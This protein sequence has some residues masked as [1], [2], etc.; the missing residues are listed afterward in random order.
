MTTPRDIL[1]E[2]LKQAQQKMTITLSETQQGWCHMMVANAETQK[3]VL[4]VV[5]TS[6]TKKIENPNQDVRQHK[7]ELPNGYSGRSFDFNYV[8]P[9]LQ[10]FFPR[11][12]MAESGWLTRSLEQVHAFTLD[13]PGKIRDTA[14]KMAFLNILK[15]IEVNQADVLEYLVIIFARLLE[16]QTLQTFAVASFR[17]NTEFTIIGVVRLLEQHFFHVYK[18]SGAARLPVIAIYT[19][20]NLMM[21]H[22]RYI[23]KQLLPL[24]S[25]TTSDNKSHGLGDVEVQNRDNTFYEVVE[26]KH[27]KP[28]TP[29]MVRVAYEKI[30]PHPLNRYYLLTT[31]FPDTQDAENVTKLVEQIYQEHGCEVIVNGAISSI[32]YYLRLIDNT[33][34]F[35]QLYT[36]HLIEEYEKGTDIKKVH[37][38]KW[39]SLLEKS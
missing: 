18:G 30:K 15:D 23:D 2:A 28:I 25:H 17:D 11:Y 4:A 27:N 33:N 38:D 32:K 9:F 8:T 39:L 24:K 10:E 14:V 1:I 36:K 7:V 6:L 5:I 19:L 21:Q 29:A 12:A 3:A 26:V 22:S 37:L 13:F 35:V 31:H 34:D 20:Y 16:F